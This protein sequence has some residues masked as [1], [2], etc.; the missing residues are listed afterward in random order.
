M[1]ILAAVELG[2]RQRFKLLLQENER[3]L[4]DLEVTANKEWLIRRVNFSVQFAVELKSSGVRYAS[5][6]M[7]LRLVRQLLGRREITIATNLEPALALFND[8]QRSALW[9]R[10][11][12]EVIDVRGIFL[13]VMKTDSVLGPPR[14]VSEKHI[15]SIRGELAALTPDHQLLRE[16]NE[17]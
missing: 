2:Y 15:G 12:S 1:E 14:L 11:F 13:A 8:D 7:L 3:A 10:L 16:V 5:G 4:D 9:S 17:G 6:E